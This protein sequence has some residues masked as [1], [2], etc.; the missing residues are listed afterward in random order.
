MAFSYTVYK[1]S[2]MG[3]M[4]AIHGLVTTDGTAGSVATGLDNIVGMSYAPKS[5]TSGV[6][7]AINAL[8]SGTATAG[9]LAVTGCTSGD[10]LYVTVFGN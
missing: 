10:L 9:T 2:T 6:K 4:R 5:Q 1:K 3:D 8:E 7:F